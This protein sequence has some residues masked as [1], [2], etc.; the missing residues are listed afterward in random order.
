MSR[1]VISLIKAVDD[2]EAWESMFGRIRGRKE[3]VQY[4]TSG[5]P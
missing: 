2:N 5:L 4:L 3:L 1:L